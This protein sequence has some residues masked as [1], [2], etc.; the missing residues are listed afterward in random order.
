[1]W[2]GQLQ[3]VAVLLKDANWPN[4]LAIVGTSSAISSVVVLLMQGLKNR[5]DAK[6]KRRDA[7]LDVAVALEGYGRLCRAT[8]HR[9]NWAKAEAER[10]G[11]LQPTHTVMLPEFVFPERVQW[12]SLSHKVVSHLRDFPAR[13]HAAREDLSPF[14]TYASPISLCE[15]VEFESATAARDALELAR[16]TRRKH[17]CVAWRPG[18]KDADLS[19]DLQAIIAEL[20]ERDSRTRTHSHRS[21]SSST[22]PV[23][24]S[25]ASVISQ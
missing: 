1:M 23:T 15:E 19:R 2:Q 16:E 18:A 14:S 20:Q 17:A 5:V 8:M 21:K 25:G 24:T 13:I 6:R 11:T 9:A 12:S 3:N 7:A 22:F 4:W 10:A